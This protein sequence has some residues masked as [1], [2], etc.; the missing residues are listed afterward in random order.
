MSSPTQKI[1]P[2]VLCRA[3]NQIQ[4][5]DQFRVYRTEPSV[6]FY[7]FCGSCEKQMPIRELYQ[8]FHVYATPEIFAAI[9]RGEDLLVRTLDAQR[10]KHDKGDARFAAEMKRR[11]ACRR[12]FIFYISQF[13]PAY[14]PGWV[15]QDICRR[16]QR[17]VQDVEAGLSP[18][19]IL[20]VPPRH[21][22]STIVSD[23]FPSW[24]FGRHPEWEIISTSYA[25]TLPTKF[26]R[27]IRDRLRDPAHQVLYPETQL[28]TD[29][30]AVENW[31]TTAGGSFTAAGVSGPITGKGAHILLV[32]DPFKDQEEASSENTREKVWEWFTS[33][34][35]TRLAPGGGVLIIQTRWHDMDLAGRAIAQM[36]ESVDAGIPEGQYDKWEIVSYPALAENDEWLFPDGNI[37]TNPLQKQIP[38]NARLLRRV[39][40]A[41]HPERY[42]VNALLMIKNRMPPSQWNALFQQN[43]VPDDG[44][45]FKKENFRMGDGL[46]HRQAAYTLFS[47]WDLAIGEK[48]RNDWTVGVVGAIDMQGN[49]HIVDMIRGRMTTYEIVDAMCHVMEKYKLYALGIEDGQIKKTLY[50]LL[51]NEMR[52][53]NL[54]TIL[55]EE[56]KPVQDK[57]VRA[58][59]L[60]S[61]MQ[62][63]QIHF[64]RGQPWYEKVEAELLRFPNGAHDDIVDALAWMARMVPRV[65]K[66]Q[67]RDSSRGGKK[68]PKSWKDSLRTQLR[69]QK[70][71]MTA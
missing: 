47:T 15:H 22:K 5:L 35:M 55:D 39:G 53:R 1:N 66:P 70:T 4:G 60:Q 10:D 34:A 46:I 2:L 30:T 29:S 49:I 13:F 27:A 51:K 32:D 42:P 19:L 58:S 9:S 45:F 17:F 8:R 11:E 54:T 31:M 18:R 12:F 25:V 16:L 61:M 52:A 56:L 33:T 7:D 40:D 28:R 26:S 71:F 14:K 36:K 44:E 6:R 37:V 48:Q 23:Y 38:E 3:C 65:P 68:K 41:L 62:L 43:P 21:G 64:T 50:P 59:V 63:G 57:K 20:T 69:G 67:V 24:V